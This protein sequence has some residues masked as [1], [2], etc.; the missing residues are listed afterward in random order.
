MNHRI[1]ERQLRTAKA[2]NWITGVGVVVAIVSLLFVYR[3]ITDNKEAMKLD[4]R[5]WVG[6]LDASPVGE[7][8]KGQATGVKITYVNTGKT[9]ARD[10]RTHVDW[11]LEETAIPAYDSDPGVNLEHSRILL[12]P[13]GKG[14]VA[15]GMSDEV[16][17]AINSDRPGY[18]FGT[19]WYDDIFGSHHWS[20]FC[21][22][23]RR[24]FREFDG[25]NTHNQSDNN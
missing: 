25:C 9:P 6:A 2:M 15:R 20:Q 19:V 23:V 10:V 12:L 7:L 1:E 17:A 5:A 8:E 16:A 13:S 3:T 24:G 21:F 4:Q 18:I 11:K 14:S 22:R